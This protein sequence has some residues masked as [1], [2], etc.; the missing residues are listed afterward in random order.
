MDDDFLR[1][2]TLCNYA[3][4]F[5]EFAFSCFLNSEYYSI[6]MSLLRRIRIDAVWFQEEMSAAFLLYFFEK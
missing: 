2:V 5:F 3:K 6:S 1:Y 4:K